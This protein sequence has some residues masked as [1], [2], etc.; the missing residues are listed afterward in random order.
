[1][2]CTT[3]KL[4]KGGVGSFLDDRISPC[5]HQMLSHMPSTSTAVHAQST[6][7]CVG[8]VCS[9]RGACSARKAFQSARIQYDRNVQKHEEQQVSSS[10]NR[11]FSLSGLHA[12][13]LSPAQHPHGRGHR[14]TTTNLP[15]VLLCVSVLQR[16]ELIGAVDFSQRQQKYARE[17]D[18]LEGSQDV[19]ASL[20]R[21]RQLMMQNLEQTHGNVSVLGAWRRGSS[22]VLGGT[23][24]GGASCCFS[25]CSNAVHA[26]A[27]GGS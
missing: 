21:T 20:R 2:Q 10:S 12:C 22:C 27:A 1:M 26:T 6:P 24:G 23:R 11:N 25:G 13:M 4:S 16:R 3:R 9:T 14:G 18:V 7:H 17:Q 8:S 15:H 19:T 5:I